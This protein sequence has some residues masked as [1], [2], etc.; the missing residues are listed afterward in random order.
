MHALAA[1]VGAQHL[2]N[3]Q[4]APEQVMDRQR[5]GSALPAGRAGSG[6]VISI[7]R[8]TCI[9]RPGRAYRGLETFPRYVSHADDPAIA[10]ATLPIRRAPLLPAA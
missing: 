6:P 8:V 5:G 4:F 9:Q 3:Q 7:D 1:A 2:G 10:W